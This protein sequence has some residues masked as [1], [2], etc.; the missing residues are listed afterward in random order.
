MIRV[1]Y[2]DDSRAQRILWLLEELNLPYEIELYRRRP[3][4]RAPK[5]LREVH[6][7]GK[8]PVIEDDGRVI[9]E[10]GAITEY[11]IDRYGAESGLR[12]TEEEALLRYRYWLHYAEG[13]AM[14]LLLQKL[15]FTKMPGQA[16]FF[17]RPVAK[18]ISR[19]V[20]TRMVDPQLRDHVAFWEDEL[21]RNGWFAGPDFT[22]ADIQMSFVVEAAADRAMEG[23]PGPATADWLRRI[24][25]RLGYQRALERGEY[26]YGGTGGTG[27]TGA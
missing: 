19:A 8:S 2:L 5:S 20:L 6:P 23:G 4:M 15:L 14:P 13:S 21:A 3:D 11:L 12:P 25:A 24:R 22:A 16:P 9:A 18:A 26:R 17:M 27:G 10:S 7:L 1:H